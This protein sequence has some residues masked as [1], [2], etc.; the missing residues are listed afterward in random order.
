LRESIKSDQRDMRGNGLPFG[1]LAERRILETE[2]DVLG[3]RRPGEQ[4]RLLE[5]DAAIQARPRD[6]IAIL[7]D[8]ATKFRLEPG[9][10]P[11]QRRLPAAARP[12]QND[13]LAGCHV[14][15]HVPQRLNGR[16]IHD[17]RLGDVAHLQP[18]L[19]L[20]RECRCP[21]LHG[22]VHCPAACGLPLASYS[23]Q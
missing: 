12:Q 5:D 6:R 16:A 2:G 1:P 18:P 10:Q 8:A 3:N 4:S 14:E 21:Q 22:D 15:R 19:S 20:V 11:Q 17:K 7:V 9:D 13:E 23:C